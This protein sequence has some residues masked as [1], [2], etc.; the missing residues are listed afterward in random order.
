M[1]KHEI[2]KKK[3][4]K[5]VKIAVKKRDVK[6]FVFMILKPLFVT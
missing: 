2:D 4:K 5:L 3:N 1:L 6:I